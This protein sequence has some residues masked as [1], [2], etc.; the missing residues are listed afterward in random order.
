MGQ[1]ARVARLWTI[2]RRRA[3]LACS[4]PERRHSHTIISCVGSSSATGSSRS[5]DVALL[6]TVTWSTLAIQGLHRNDFIMG[7]KTHEAYAEQV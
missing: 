5:I 4:A 1:A 3:E 7:A 6:A 2:A